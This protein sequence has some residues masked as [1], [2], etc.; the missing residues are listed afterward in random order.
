MLGTQTRWAWGL[1]GPEPDPT[2]RVLIGLGA[3]VRLL[4]RRLQWSVLCGASGGRVGRAWMK[5]HRPF[6]VL[7]GGKLSDRC[8]E[9]LHRLPVCAFCRLSPRLLLPVGR[10]LL[11]PAS[12]TAT[13]RHLQLHPAQELL[14]R[15]A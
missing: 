10:R 11:P 14:E 8:G 9:R 6:H 12:L 5:P 7:L 4:G 13:A 1:E 15:P 3:D 2:Q